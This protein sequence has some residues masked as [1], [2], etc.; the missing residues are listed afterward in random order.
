MGLFTYGYGHAVLEIGGS[1][2]GRGTLIGGLFHPTRQLAMFTLPNMSYIKI[3]NLFRISPRGEA[4]NYSQY[5]SPSF[6]VPKYVC[7]Y[8]YKYTRMCACMY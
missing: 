2:P 5:A 6:V 3:V 1:N 8:A 7:M 4:V